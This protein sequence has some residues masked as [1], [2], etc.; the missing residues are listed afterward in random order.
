LIA[1][2]AGRRIQAA[3]THAAR[4]PYAQ[5]D[6]VKRAIAQRLRED[7]VTGLICSASCGA[8]LLALQ[9]AC[10]AG[11]LCWIV[12]PYSVPVFRERSVVDRGGG[13]PWGEIFD[14]VV[15]RANEHGQLIVLD[16][17][18]ADPGAFQKTNTAIL[19]RAEAIASAANAKVEALAVWDGKA[20]DGIDVTSHFVDEAKARR[21]P[22]KRIGILT[23]GQSDAT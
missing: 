11:V 14:A 4:F 20:D 6:R 19:D 5:T 2:L 7:H 15:G 3:G 8:D 17:N 10:E 23:S 13:L 9:A 16:L 12:L 22:V 21:F 18:P 1:A